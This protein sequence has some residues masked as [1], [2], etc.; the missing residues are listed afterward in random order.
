MIRRF[1]GAEMEGTSTCTCISLR[2]FDTAWLATIPQ[3]DTI[4]CSS[5]PIRIRPDSSG[6]VSAVTKWPIRKD[7]PFLY[8]GYFQADALAQYE[9]LYGDDKVKHA[10]ASRTSRMYTNGRVRQKAGN[11]IIRIRR[12]VG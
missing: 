4:R 1:D 3:T 2:L 7:W 8:E 12:G 9:G 6:R 11:P 10:A 5:Q